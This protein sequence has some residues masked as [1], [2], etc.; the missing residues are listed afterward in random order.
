MKNIK[1]LLAWTGLLAASLLL[2]GCGSQKARPATSSPVESSVKQSKKAKS[3]SSHQSARQ[4]QTSQKPASP[5]KTSR[6]S[7]QRGKGAAASSKSVKMEPVIKKIRAYLT[8]Y[9][10]NS[11]VS[12]EFIDLS[13]NRRQ[14]VGVNE[15][16]GM[17]AASCAKLP[18]AAYTQYLVQSGKLSYS[19]K[20][21][22]TS[23]AD[24]TPNHM[25]KGGTGVLQNQN[26][27]GKQYSVQTLLEDAMVHSDNAASNQLLYHLCNKDQAS[28]NAFLNKIAGISSYSKTM[29]TLQAA[30]V[31]AYLHSQNGPVNQYLSATDWKSEKIGTLPVRVDHKIGIN[32][33]INNDVGYVYA[34][35]PFVLAI[36]TNGWSNDQIAA[37]AQ[38]IYDLAE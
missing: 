37:V 20:L 15:N 22:Y 5:Q 29:T 32:G 25:V 30:R 34:K 7:G 27:E 10:G 21:T 9:A 6:Q 8:K 13:N 2:V 17:Y 31:M 14:S 23:A 24:D 11:A 38:K 3:Q 26:P 18:V 19:S 12:V 1:H 33:A 4:K 28:F 16:T 36:F 35:K